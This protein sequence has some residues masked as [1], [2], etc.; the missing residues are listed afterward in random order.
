[1]TRTIEPTAKGAIDAN[2]AADSGPELGVDCTSGPASDG[3]V[4]II[5]FLGFS[6]GLRSSEG[7]GRSGGTN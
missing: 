1:M 7:V 5:G 3:V 2:S 4:E 6:G